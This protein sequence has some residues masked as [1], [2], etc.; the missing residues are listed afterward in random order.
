[1]GEWMTKSGALL[2][3]VFASIGYFAPLLA[4]ASGVAA[5]A[6]LA[7]LAVYRPYFIGLAGLALLYSCFETFLAQ[8]RRRASGQP[9]SMIGGQE[10]RLAVTTGLV[11]LA[12][13]FPHLVGHSSSLEGSLYEGRGVVVQVDD[14]ARTVT[15]SHDAIA[16]VLPAMSMEYGVD[17]PVGLTRLRA[18]DRVR[19][20]LAARGVEFVVVDIEKERAP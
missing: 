20:R 17:A 6:A 2:A 8:Y 7:S 18:G 16:G 9:G 10:I 13:F 19:F 4:S 12:I 5:F 14:R 11:L 3:A 1:M 15:L